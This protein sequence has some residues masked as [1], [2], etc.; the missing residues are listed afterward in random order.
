MNIKRGDFLA[1]LNEAIIG[2]SAKETIQQSNC[3]VFKD[4]RLFAYNDSIMVRTKSPLDFDAVVNATDLTNLL[5]KIPDDDVEVIKNGNEILIKG[6]RR[7]AGIQCLASVELDMG[8]VPTPESWSR[9]AEGTLHAIQ[10]ACGVCTSDEAQFLTS[11][12]HVTPMLVQATD[13]N[14]LL[15]VDFT[16]G[17][18]GFPAEVLIPAESASVIAGLEVKKVSIGQGWVHFKTVSGAEISCRCS[19]EQYHQNLDDVLKMDKPENITL[20]TNLGEIIDR[21]EVFYDNAFSAR[22]GVRI[23]NGEISITSRK[24]SG[25]YKERKGIK[26]TGRALEFDI[27]PKFLVEVLERTRDIEVDSRKLKLTSGNVQFMASLITRGEK[28]KAKEPEPDRENDTTSGE[29]TDD[30]ISF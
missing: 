5:A 3:F 9:L 29:Y 7:K 6:K 22:V 25:W 18:T 17:G 4:G 19:H 16:A 15:R 11:C 10:Q 30:D 27:H 26:Y 13:K 2:V 8:K 28:T 21:A 14:R 1:K 20:P 12:V 23:E 24:D